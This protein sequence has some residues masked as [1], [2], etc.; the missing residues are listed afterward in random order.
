VL[1]V[2]VTGLF[3]DSMEHGVDATLRSTRYDFYAALYSMEDADELTARARAAPGA[4]EV[5]VG[6]TV[7][8]QVVAPG[9]RY[10]TF[11][12]GVPENPR[13][14]VPVDF[15]GRVLPVR[16]GE[17][18]LPREVAK[19]I[20][21]QRGATVTV[22]VLP[23]GPEF[24]VRVGELLDT[25]SGSLA[26][27]PLGDLQARLGLAGRANTVLVAAP[28]SAR[29]AVR[30]SLQAMPSLAAFQDLDALREMIDQFVA[31]GLAMVGMMLLLA[32]VL[33]AAL[34]F[35]TATLGILER[36]RELATQ[37]ALGRSTRAIALTMTLE[38]GL[39]ALLGLAVGIPVGL[40]AGHVVVAAYSTDMLSLPFA[41]SARTLGITAFGVLLVLL[42]AQWP[43]LRTVS[44]MNVAEA[45]RGDDD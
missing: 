10:E 21:V 16:P 11:V 24:P 19:R 33:A 4:T 25:I 15:D 14:F 36:Q 37:R 8:V 12:Q 3:L 22:R 39:L 42:V 40:L 17:V 44:R 30:A 26:V 18:V 28:P 27:M 29:P 13:L 34:L 31:L 45:V 41:V 23:G 43:G 1:L 9:G 38:N 2:L 35:N 5:E 6:L 20:G 32:V 7:P